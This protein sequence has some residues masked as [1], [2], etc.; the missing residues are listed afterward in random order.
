MAGSENVIVL[1]DI[2]FLCLNN[3]K[4]MAY[5]ASIDYSRCLQSIFTHNVSFKQNAKL[6]HIS[7]HNIYI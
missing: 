4:S 2:L 5:E 6:S 1:L 3:V 7:L